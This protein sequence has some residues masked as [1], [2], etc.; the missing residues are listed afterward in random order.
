MRLCRLNEAGI[1]EFEAF[2]DAL[3]LDA[4]RVVPGNLLSDRQFSEPLDPAVD[5]ELQA[6]PDRFAAARYLHERFTAAGLSDVERDKGLWCWLTLLYFDVLCPP[7]RD[8]AHRPGARARYVPES[9]NFRRYYRHLL[10]GPYRIYRAHRDGPEC[11]L[12]VLCQPLHKP[13]DIVEQLAARQE[14]VTNRAV[15][16]AASMLYVDLDTRKPKRGSQTKAIGAVRRLTDVLNQF[17][18]T[19]DLYAAQVAELLGI[20]PE[21]FDRFRPAA[22]Q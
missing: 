20:L 15:M 6:F 11:A 3:S 14:L 9:A 18:V 19:W 13:G 21:E 17:D 10:A 12:A 1:R 5:V 16:Q 2:L 22:T 8:G 4:M 7:E